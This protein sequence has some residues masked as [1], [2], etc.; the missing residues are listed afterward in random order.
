MDGQS[1][2]SGLVNVGSLTATL[3]N[4]H[5]A[6]ELKGALESVLMS[7]VNATAA[8]TYADQIVGACFDTS[9]SLADLELSDLK[10]LGVPLGHRKV[11]MRA[12]FAGA[13]PMPVGSPVQPMTPM[14]AAQPVP[15]PAEGSRADM[16]FRRE[17]PSVDEATGRMRA[18]E[19]HSFGLALRGHLRDT[20]RYKL[21]ED[22]WERV[23]KV[24]VDIRSTYVH[25]DDDDA[26]LARLL[27]SCGR[28]GMP[29]AVS[30]M[31]ST[32]VAADMGMRAWQSLCRRHFRSTEHAG[33]VLKSKVRTPG[34]EKDAG[35]VA[36][37]LTQWDS[38]MAEALAKGYVF[39]QHD[40][41]SALYG[42]VEGLEE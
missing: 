27:V 32:H 18:A 7:G 35:R 38:D 30:V 28:H 17:W 25:A 33:K 36:A 40:Q 22:L 5:T 8:G 1:A 39:D 26:Y 24:D 34:A 37:R 31:C 14:Q 10:E 3:Q 19:F 12:I 2:S 11:V 13:L 41:R 4:M 23:D 20:G 42:L 16:A 21:A 15:A 29:G 9:A 6:E